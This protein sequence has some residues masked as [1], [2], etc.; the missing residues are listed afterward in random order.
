MYWSR[1]RKSTWNTVKDNYLKL[2]IVAGVGT[3][4]QSAIGD[5]ASKVMHF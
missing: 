5:V 4:L 3:E 2:L 1:T